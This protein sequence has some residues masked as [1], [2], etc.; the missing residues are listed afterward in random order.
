M[1][2]GSKVSSATEAI[3]AARRD[4]NRVMDSIINNLNSLMNENRQRR[5]DR[6]MTPSQR[7][8]TGKARSRTAN[9]SSSLHTAKPYRPYRS[10]FT[11]IEEQQSTTKT[12]RSPYMATAEE[13]TELVPTAKSVSFI[14]DPPSVHSRVATAKQDNSAFSDTSAGSDRV[15]TAV[16]PNLKETTK[17]G[18]TTAIKDTS[19]GRE[20]RRARSPTIRKNTNSQ[21]RSHAAPTSSS[22]V[23]ARSTTPHK[24]VSP[25]ERLCLTTL[26][27]AISF[28]SD[29]ATV[30]PQLSQTM[31]ALRRGKLFGASKSPAPE[32][33]ITT[34]VRAL[35]SSR[36][37]SSEAR[38]AA[39]LGTPCG[40]IRG[41]LQEQGVVPN[42]VTASSAERPMANTALLHGP[43]GL[44][45]VTIPDTAVLHG[46]SG[47]SIISTATS[48]AGKTSTIRLQQQPTM[49]KQMTTEI[50]ST[51]TAPTLLAAPSEQQPKMEQQGIIVPANADVLHG[52][53]GST[54]VVAPDTAILHGA[55]GTE[56]ISTAGAQ[57]PQMT[58]SEKQPVMEHQRV[59]V[60]AN[61]DVLHG[62]SG[63]TIVVA[64]DTAVLHGPSGTGIIS[65][66][67]GNALPYE[68]PR[69]TSQLLYDTSTARSVSRPPAKSSATTLPVSSRRSRSR[70]TDPRTAR[71][72]SGPRTWKGVHEI[73]KAT[74]TTPSKQ[75]M[76]KATH[77]VPH[78]SSRPTAHVTAEEADL[79][80]AKS[81][82]VIKEETITVT[83][84]VV[85]KYIS[86]ED[87]TNTAR[88]PSPLRVGDVYE[89]E[90]SSVRGSSVSTA[91]SDRRSANMRNMRSTSVG[92]RT[93]RSTSV[94]TL[95][96]S[97]AYAAQCRSGTPPPALITVSSTN[98]AR[99]A[100]P[101]QL[102]RST[103][104]TT[105]TEIF[106]PT[107]ASGKKPVTGAD[108]E[109]WD[110]ARNASSD[111]SASPRVSTARCRTPARKVNSPPSPIPSRARLPSSSE[112]F[113]ETSKEKP[114]GML[115]TFI[116][117]LSQTLYSMV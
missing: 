57:T 69:S 92:T 80:T 47:L 70:L 100:T 22:Y 8:P 86:A 71:S 113:M 32:S 102:G 103:K 101:V 16:S 68:A 64:P 98:T 26:S 109:C 49:Q 38:T 96:E 78:D 9:S 90:G 7:E 110:L 41:I 62:P 72:T 23:T 93:A 79:A 18:E 97:N 108:K 19:T 81:S 13:T 46:P 60:P 112:V 59:T 82:M 1:T 61:A 21:A 29:D 31:D 3:A 115:E 85:T 48:S 50:D 43:S 6:S 39:A 35:R 83:R 88:I 111:P 99:L 30:Q 77:S 104:T 33:F 67:H 45:I 15:S 89:G 105:R 94:G 58:S 37:K 14:A 76:M 36:S 34:G 42:I 95:T 84:R 55:S 63:S 5:R 51:A 66:T 87:D 40:R 52:P 27:C 91:R 25:R 10:R 54:I 74:P 53:S 44:S 56:I 4:A 106:S 17:E 12:A 107:S 75:P 28:Q 117:N 114:S 24:A 65:T 20:E 73:L 11:G 116:V 2:G